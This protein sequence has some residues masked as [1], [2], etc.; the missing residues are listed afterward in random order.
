[1]L[2]KRGSF[3]AKCIQATHTLRARGNPE[4]HMGAIRATG[5]GERGREREEGPA[6]RVAIGW[7]DVVGYARPRLMV[8][9]SG[10]CGMVAIGGVPVFVAD[11]LPG[12]RQ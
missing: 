1:M 3:P 12:N 9:V 10:G 2:K 5:G 11:R 7:C 8:C 6:E 4:L